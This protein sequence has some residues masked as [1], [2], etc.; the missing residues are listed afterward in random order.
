MAIAV[1]RNRI[2]V[3]GETTT[4]FFIPNSNTRRN[5][6]I[7]LL[8]FKKNGSLQNSF[9]YGGPFA[10]GAL[11]SGLDLEFSQEGFPIILGNSIAT[12][13]QK[14]LLIEHYRDAW[15]N[16]RGSSS[17]NP[18]LEQYAAKKRNNKDKEQETEAEE[19][20]L[21]AIDVDLNQKLDCPKQT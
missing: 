20:S 1:Y 21:V 3:S 8:E 6:D 2:W 13:K 17:N 15:K 18:N 16:C 14:A 12:S 11:G 4:S 7:F 5:R 19:M 10:D 9:T